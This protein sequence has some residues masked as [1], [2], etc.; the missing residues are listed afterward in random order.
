MPSERLSNL[1]SHSDTEWR[2][3]DEDLWQHREYKHFVAAYEDFMEKGGDADA[4]LFRYSSDHDIS[5]QELA[6]EHHGYSQF[7]AFRQQQAYGCDVERC[8]FY[9]ETPFRPD[10]LLSDLIRIL[11]PEFPGLPPLRYYKPLSD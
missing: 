11:H 6:R 7:R 2:A 8:N 4:W 9:E 10:W 1:K 3:T 5:Y